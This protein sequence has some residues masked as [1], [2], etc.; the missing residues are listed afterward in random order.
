MYEN[1]YLKILGIIICFQ[2]IGCSNSTNFDSKSEA[3]KNIAYVSNIDSLM[4]AK[5]AAHVNSIK[6]KRLFKASKLV[7]KKEEYLLDYGKVTTQITQ[8]SQLNK[9]EDQFDQIDRIKFVEEQTQ[10]SSG[11]K[12]IDRFKQNSYGL[13]DILIVI[14]NSGSM[15]E[16]QKKLAGKL[17]PLLSQIENTNWKIGVVTTDADSKCMTAIINK[18]DIDLDKSFSDAINAGTGGSNYEQGIL[19]AKH[20]LDCEDSPWIRDGSSIAV[21]FVSDE[22]N[23]DLHE[24]ECRE[25]SE[26]KVE[27]LDHLNSIRPDGRA[28]V[29]GLFSDPENSCKQ[30]SQDDKVNT[31]IS[32]GFQYKWLVQNTQGAYGSICDSDYTSTL[33]KISKDV[34]TIMKNQ[35]FLKYKP[36]PRPVVEELIDGKYVELGLDSYVIDGQTITLAQPP[37]VGSTIR[38]EYSYNAT[39]RFNEIT[40]SNRPVEETIKILFNGGEC[41]GKCTY[42]LE[43]SG[44][45]Y[46][47]IFHEYPTDGTNVKVSYDVWS[48]LKNEFQ[49]KLTPKKIDSVFVSGVEK[50]LD[51]DYQIDGNV[52][53]FMSD[54]TPPPSSKITVL[55]TTIGNPIL[56]YDLKV[57][58]ENI[59]DLKFTDKNNGDAL[60]PEIENGQIVFDEESHQHERHVKVTYT[61]YSVLE[62]NLPLSSTPYEENFQLFFDGSECKSKAMRIENN[63]IKPDQCLFSG[64][65]T[66]LV[67]YKI[68]TNYLD[69][70]AIPDSIPLEDTNLSIIVKVNGIPTTNFNKEGGNKVRVTEKLP[71][72][73]DVEVLI[74]NKEF[75]DK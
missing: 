34:E 63:A 37:K 58:F 55:Y 13:L 59:A 57:D 71:A 65:K 17:K 66:A 41:Y 29:Y 36:D 73:A 40:L 52:I 56:K 49:L 32:D 62:S 11:I 61:D 4:K 9:N 10:G 24:G 15:G 46:K 27:F 38:V 25:N 47:I 33:N 26:I 43:Q 51:D 21:L 22:D 74:A 70:T 75:I 64:A 12:R 68:L 23:C 1:N 50:K 54:K 39:R 45:S 48:E 67:K 35:I 5:A 30:K 28:K 69:Y 2:V 19:Q 14:D 53:R 7:E 44:D 8:L 16:E 31:A 20:A 18:E 3:K 72:E 60:N 6:F 42:N